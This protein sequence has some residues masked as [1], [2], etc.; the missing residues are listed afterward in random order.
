MSPARLRP[1]L[2]IPWQAAALVAAAAY[3]IRSAMRGLDFRPEPLDLLV[4]GGIAIIIAARVLVARS[5]ERDSE[6]DVQE[7]P[8]A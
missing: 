8:D 5:I 3:V 4:F 6:T 1:E 2:R 7:P